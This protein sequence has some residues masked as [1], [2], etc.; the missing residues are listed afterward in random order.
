MISAVLLPTALFMSSPLWCNPCLSEK[1][2]GG[3]DI[4]EDS[5]E[6]KYGGDMWKALG[7]GNRINNYCLH[8][9]VGAAKGLSIYYVIHDGGAGV[10]PIY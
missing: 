7:K 6:E 9:E 5:V 2:C 3:H 8:N 10:F 1:F 4:G